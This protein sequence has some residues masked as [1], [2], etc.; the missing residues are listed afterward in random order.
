MGNETETKKD[1]GHKAAVAKLEAE[2]SSAKAELTAAR[3]EIAKLDV[4]LEER[5]VALEQAS[6]EKADMLLVLQRMPSG[7]GGGVLVSAADAAE[8]A[9]AAGKHQKLRDMRTKAMEIAKPGAQF[10]KYIVG[11]SGTVRDGEGVV[12]PG[13][14]ISV[15]VDELPAGEWK[16][17]EPS[18]D[19][20]APAPKVADTASAIQ[21]RDGPMSAAEKAIAQ[22]DALKAQRA[23]DREV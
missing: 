12:K 4:R 16:V 8:A 7:G 10:V 23:S 2:L 15:S 18:V 22:R 17:W 5:T 3:L 19:S 1:D 6:R 21:R 9:R 20:D 13:T 11:P 14:V